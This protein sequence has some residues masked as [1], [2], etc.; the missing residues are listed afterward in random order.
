MK[1]ICETI[2]GGLELRQ[3]LPRREGCHHEMSHSNSCQLIGAQGFKQEDVSNCRFVAIT[4]E[5]L[6]LLLPQYLVEKVRPRQEP[7]LPQKPYTSINRTVL[8]KGKA[9]PVLRYQTTSN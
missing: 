1:D 4:Y 8:N 2:T 6:M 5:G 9:I 7:P 3:V